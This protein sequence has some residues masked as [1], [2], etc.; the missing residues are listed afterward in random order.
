MAEGADSVKSCEID[1]CLFQSANP[2]MTE[3]LAMQG[4]LST[5]QRIRTSNLRFR[6]PMLYPVELGVRWRFCIW[7]GFWQKLWTLATKLVS[8]RD[9][10]SVGLDTLD[11]DFVLREADR[12]RT[13]LVWFSGF[14]S[15]FRLWLPNVSA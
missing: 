3:A 10:S 13:G 8:N 2:E 1:F 6:R 12:D 4:L 15:D 5:P 7:L 9:V 14:A 11:A